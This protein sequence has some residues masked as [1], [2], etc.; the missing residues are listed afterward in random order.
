MGVAG[1]PEPI[2]DAAAWG[3][4]AAFE[5]TLDRLAV[6]PVPVGRQGG[7]LG[8]AAEWNQ[9]CRCAQGNTDGFLDFCSGVFDATYE[10]LQQFDGFR[11]TLVS[12][13]LNVVAL[14]GNTKHGR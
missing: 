2:A 7:D 12:V 1:V 5:D 10:V 14:D 8:R 9:S 3:W 11:V 13:G 4:R 6:H